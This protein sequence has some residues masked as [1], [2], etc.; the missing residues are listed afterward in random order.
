MSKGTIDV[1]WLLEQWGRW[2]ASGGEQLGYPSMA[3]FRRLLGTTVASAQVDDATAMWV[4][5]LVS[6]LSV[7]HPR[8]A[9]ALALRYVCGMSQRRVAGA[10]NCSQKSAQSLLE[11][12]EFW[13]EAKL[14]PD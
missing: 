1:Q 8:E 9:A 4:D 2:A 7:D 5:G 13:M 11:R 14:G 3:P 6:R 12:A 10:L